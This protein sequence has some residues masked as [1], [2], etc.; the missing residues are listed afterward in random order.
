MMKLERL[1][2]RESVS[3]RPPRRAS[4]ISQALAVIQAHEIERPRP[5]G[6]IVR[7]VRQ[8]W[9]LEE[10]YRLTHDAYL[11]R[12]Y[13]APQADGKLIHYPSLEH[14]PETSVMIALEHKDVMGT[15]SVTIDGPC[16]LNVDRDFSKAVQSVRRE[17]RRLGAVWRMATRHS[18]RSERRVLMALMHAGVCQAFDRQELDTFLIVVH[19]RHESAY[20]RLL[21]M[22]T[23]AR[24]AETGGLKNAP[25]VLMRCDLE[26]CPERWLAVVPS[27]K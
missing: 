19:P 15:V 12:G 3:R 6:L 10:V 13:C 16:G 27:T 4:N 7:P 9:E 2:V 17:G 24:S 25:G 26:R 23:V 11:E 18:L 22:R 5:A 8:R 14:T 21:D 20:R 1:A